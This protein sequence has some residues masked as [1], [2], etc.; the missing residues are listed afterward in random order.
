MLRRSV[1]P[2]AESEHLLPER[3]Y[4]GLACPLGH[5]LDACLHEVGKLG[6]EPNLRKLLGEQ[7]R[8]ML[9]QLQALALIVR[10][11]AAI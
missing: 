3:T 8:K 4:L 1:E 11:N 10:S 5:P 7:L 9:R 6:F 2:A